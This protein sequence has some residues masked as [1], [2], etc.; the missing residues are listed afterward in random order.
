MNFGPDFKH[1]PQ[2]EDDDVRPVSEL[3]EQV[4]VEHTL[5]DLLYHVADRLN[6]DTWQ[7]LHVTCDRDY[8]CDTDI[9]IRWRIYFNNTV[10]NMLKY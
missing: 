6:T 5:G 3:A 10:L 8:T 1:K 9:N 2:E 7:G 4:A